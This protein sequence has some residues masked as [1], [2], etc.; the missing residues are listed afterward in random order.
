MDWQ[1]APW[2]ITWMVGMGVT[3]CI[4]SFNWSAPGGIIGGV[5]FFKHVFPSGGNDPLSLGP[6]GS[7]WWPI[8][9]SAVFSIVI[10]VWALA[11][12]LPGHKVDE[13]V[14]DVYPPPVTE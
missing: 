11:S 3:T 12:R 2:I 1:A 4:S 5:G 6:N 14:R 10:Y 13:Y 8:V 9:I 7:V